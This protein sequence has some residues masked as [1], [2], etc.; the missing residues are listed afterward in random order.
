MNYSKRIIPPVYNDPN[1][2]SDLNFYVANGFPL[3][4]CT[5]YVWGRWLELGV[6]PINLSTGS[7]QGL[8]A[9]LR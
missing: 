5:T 9:T 4:N 1:Y 2:F 6:S 3:P 7:R 8:L